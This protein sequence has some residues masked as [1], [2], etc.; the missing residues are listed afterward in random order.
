MKPE[1]N[2]KINIITFLN[3]RRIAATDFRRLVNWAFMMEL[4]GCG[5]TVARK[6]CE[7][8]RIDPNGHSK[9]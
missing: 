7:S 6:L 1:D 5:S 3:A 9:S 4:V 8:I 2:Y